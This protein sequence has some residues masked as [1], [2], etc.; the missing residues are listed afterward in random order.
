MFSEAARYVTLSVGVRQRRHR[1]QCDS[2]RPV[3]LSAAASYS[4]L[5]T[6]QSSLLF[7]CTSQ[8]WRFA[9]AERTEQF[10]LLVT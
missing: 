10:Q 6:V 2:R 1:A 4:A 3:I 7:R 5:I 8:K 9:T